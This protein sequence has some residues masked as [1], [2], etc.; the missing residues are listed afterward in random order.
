[1][2]SSKRCSYGIGN[3][4]LNKPQARPLHLW[5]MAG[6]KPAATRLIIPN[7]TH[8]IYAATTTLFNR[9]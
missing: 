6:G 7:D 4:C 1:M 2:I 5:A 9:Q 8:F 3:D